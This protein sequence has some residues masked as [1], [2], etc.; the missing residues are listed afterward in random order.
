MLF[1]KTTRFRDEDQILVFVSLSWQYE[2]N[3]EAVFCV[4]QQF[5]GSPRFWAYKNE[6]NVQPGALTVTK[7]VFLDEKC[8]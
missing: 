7:S 6:H 4:F 5:S 1:E 3:L 8:V 2:T